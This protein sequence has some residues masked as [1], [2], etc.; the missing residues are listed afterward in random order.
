[1]LNYLFG[2]LLT[3]LS[4]V[5]DALGTKPNI[6]YILADDLGYGELSFMWPGQNQILTPK[7]SQFASSGTVFTDA[8]AGAPQ[9]TPSRTTLMT[10]RTL[11]SS[12]L[13]VNRGTL[14]GSAAGTRLA[15]SAIQFLKLSV[16]RR[17]YL[18]ILRVQLKHLQLFQPCSRTLRVIALGILAS[19]CLVNLAVRRNLRLSG[20]MSRL[21]HLTVPMDGTTLFLFNGS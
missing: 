9:C 16:M 15:R 4:F 17:L 12:P 3:L 7:L 18:G 14:C 1:M 6:L 2:V 10:G 8:Y 19:G 13:K 5:V 11:G 21:V 20:L